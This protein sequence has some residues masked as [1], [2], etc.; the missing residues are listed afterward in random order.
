[1]VA[2]EP[3]DTHSVTTRNKNGVE[4]YVGKQALPHLSVIY[5]AILLVARNIWQWMMEISVNNELQWIEKEMIVAYYKL[6]E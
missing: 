6:L 2:Q 5:F 3:E 1:V 4:G